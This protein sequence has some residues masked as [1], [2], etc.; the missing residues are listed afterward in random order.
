MI[1][2]TFSRL[3]LCL[4]AFNGYDECCISMKKKHGLGMSI[5]IT[6]IHSSSHG[7]DEGSG[8]RAVPKRYDFDWVGCAG[9]T[10]RTEAGWDLYYPNRISNRISTSLG[11][12]PG[13]RYLIQIR[14]QRTSR[15]IFKIFCIARE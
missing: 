1:G 14:R 3:V 5:C 4:W 2:L 11:I 13:R 6:C 8:I 15:S 7:Q 9:P 12:F 10:V